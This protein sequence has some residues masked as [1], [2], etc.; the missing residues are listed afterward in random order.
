MT[1]VPIP[2]QALSPAPSTPQFR[3]DGL[4]YLYEHPSLNI[5]LQADYLK[6][7]SDEFTAE[8]TVE[9]LSAVLPP[10]L[11]QA[12]MNLSSGPARNTLAKHLGELT[13]TLPAQQWGRIIEQFCV[14]I[15][16]RERQGEPLIRV[17]RLHDVV[18]AGDQIEQLLPA[19]KPTLWYGR[20]G[21]AKGWMAVAAA[22]C[23]QAGL[24][25]A[26]L[27]VRQGTALY[28]DWEDNEE[29]LN[30]RV[31]AIAAGLDLDETPE[32]AYRKCRRTLPRDLNTISRY[33]QELEASLVIVDS[34]GPAAGAVGE[35]GSYEDVALGLFDALRHL[36]PATI[37]LIDHVVGASLNKNELVGKSMGSIYKMA[38]A[39][40]A[41]EI[42]ADDD[43]PAGEWQIG[44]FQTKPRS[45]STFA[46]IPAS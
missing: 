45:I 11:H 43:T 44:F 4:G 18:R 1:S 8:I 7:R 12:R 24:P 16:R 14:S 38:E 17:G 46:S 25:L 42:R 37:L 40:A 36:E 34:V 6:E 27:R 29:T 15:M 21:V 20:Q 9:N 41:W 2:G 3:R 32:I 31:Q 39:R 26:G 10:H 23:T 19:G 28:L 35:R 30:E 13:P 22:V 5:R 33:V